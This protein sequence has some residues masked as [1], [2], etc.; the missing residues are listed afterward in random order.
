MEPK[1]WTT[2][3]IFGLIQGHPNHVVLVLKAVKSAFVTT[4]IQ[5]SLSQEWLAIA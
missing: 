2:M 5:R 4:C 3:A 1:T